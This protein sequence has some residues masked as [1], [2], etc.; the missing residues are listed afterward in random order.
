[1]L[2]KV[3]IVRGLVDD[4]SLNISDSHVAASIENNLHEVGD[5]GTSAEGSLIELVEL[6]LADGLDGGGDECSGLQND[7][8]GSGQVGQAG[9]GS[10]VRSVGIEGTTDS[11]VNCLSGGEGRVRGDY[12]NGGLTETRRQDD[13]LVALGDCGVDGEVVT[14]N[15]ASGHTSDGQRELNGG[16]ISNINATNVVG[17]NRQEGGSRSLSESA[18]DGETNAVG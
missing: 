4:T 3:V 14:G 16:E 15:H 1:M 13:G 7:G 2:S 5:L 17:I 6:T 11:H 10:S 8:G 18:I 9:R 12:I